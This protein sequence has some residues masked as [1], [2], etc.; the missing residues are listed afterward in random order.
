MADTKQLQQHQVPDG[1]VA[2]CPWGYPLEVWSDKMI[3][4]GLKHLE[5]DLA[6]GVLSPSLFR[7]L[8]AEARGRGLALGTQ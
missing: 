3:E 2:N 7:A 1:M 6:H 5:D 8:D 4:R